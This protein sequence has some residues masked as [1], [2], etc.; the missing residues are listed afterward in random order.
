MK[1]HKT[2]IMKEY[3]IAIEL[4]IWIAWRP[5]DSYVYHSPSNFDSKD[6]MNYLV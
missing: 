6:F 4:S 3:L 2:N 5:I 1:M